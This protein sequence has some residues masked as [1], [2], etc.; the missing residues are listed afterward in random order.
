MSLGRKYEAA[1]Q[2]LPTCTWLIILKDIKLIKLVLAPRRTFKI[3][4]QSEI[5][6]NKCILHTDGQNSSHAWF[7]LSLSWKL[8]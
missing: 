6:V 2:G 3:I 4:L 7:E 8:F 5:Q 1:I